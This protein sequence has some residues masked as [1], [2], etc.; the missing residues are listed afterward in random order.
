MNW[1]TNKTLK[2][3]WFAAQ[4]QVGVFLLL[5]WLGSLSTFFLS[6]MVGW[7]YD[8]SFQEGISKSAL[9]KKFGLDIQSMEVF[10]GI[11]TLVILLKFG[12]QLFE[13][14]GINKAADTFIYRLTGKLYRKQIHWDPEAFGSRPF[15][16]YLLRYSG[17][18]TSIRSMLI[19]GIHRAIRDG[20]FLLSGLGL[21]FWINNTW[22]LWLLSMAVIGIPLFLYLDKKQLSTI[23]EKRNS[24][25]ELLNF[26]TTSFAKQRMIV[27]KGNSEY[28]FRGFRRRNKRVLAASNNYKKWESIRYSLINATGPLLIGLL[29]AV[30]HFSAVVS[31][32]GELLTFL[33]VLAALIP[34][35]RSIIKAPN[36]IQKGMISLKKIES[37]IRKNGKQIPKPESIGAGK[38]LALSK[39]QPVA[40]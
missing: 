18:M 11:M 12:L 9:L 37:L 38:I 40:K 20:L 24:K 33:L 34:A 13:R 5:G 25:N 30:L 17:D 27:E 15:G 14:V 16:K 39:S 6:L 10:F 21:L 32:P 29:L 23:P 19:N 4:P 36:L 28:N 26:V 3:K 2:R 1:L 8:L 7:F 22:T 35:F 31:T